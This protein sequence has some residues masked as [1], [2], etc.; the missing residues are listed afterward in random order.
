MMVE[1]RPELEGSPE[2]ENP[3]AGEHII[4]VDQF[5]PERLDYLFGL[6]QQM[7][8]VV[9]TTGS[10]DL[11]RGRVLANL[12][13]EPSTRT[14]SSFTAA[15]ERLGGSVIPINE[16]SYSSVT[17]G[18]NLPDTVR[19]L[20]CYSDVIVL[21]HPE[22]GSAK[23]ASEY[24]PVPV[25][26]AGDGPGEHP[27]QALL[28]LFTIVDKLGEVRG[29]HVV[30]VGDLKFGRTVHSLA[31]L[32]S[33]LDRVQM[34]FVSP[35]ELRMPP[36]ILFRL[37]EKK[38]DFQE[39]EEFEPAVP[40]ADV[41]YLTRVQKERF[42]NQEEYE[43][44]KDKYVVVPETLARAK[45]NM[46]LMHPLPRVYELDMAVDRDPRAVY[47]REQMQNGMYVRMALLASVLGKVK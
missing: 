9:Q 44:V 46:I 33:T 5:T 24:S 31:K 40:L 13:Y 18:E 11:L 34:T 36:E 39:I 15:M 6:T 19:T 1:R 12:F 4:S 37:R 45:E 8:E 30:M 26:N 2:R 42:D 3:F 25:V 20:A 35:K 27:T 29:K 17:K 10:V 21:R 28:D 14:S 16:V 22:V 23:L 41:I 38:V 47:I 7:R 32:L 43:K